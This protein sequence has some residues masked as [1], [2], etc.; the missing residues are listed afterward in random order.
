MRK[1]SKYRP[2][3][4]ILNT[5]DYVLSGMMP[6]VNL[7]DKLVSLQLKNHF[8]LDDLRMGKATRDDIDTLIAAF[9]ITEALAKQKIG[10]EYLEEIKQA[11]DALYDCAKRGVEMNYRFI[12]KGPELK[13]INFVMQ[14]HDEQLKAATVKD[15]EVATNY[16]NQCLI[17]KRA[18]PIILK[19]K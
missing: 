2:K 6:M 1:R 19:T 17:N 13:S 8:A 9:N 18:R 12:V 16:V 4:V 3:P 11:Q 15:I 14:L 10:D 7:K 5:M